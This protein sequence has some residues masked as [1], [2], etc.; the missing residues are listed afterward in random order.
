MRT[1][2]ANSPKAVAR[3]LALGMLIDGVGSFP[4]PSNM[5]CRRASDRALK[6]T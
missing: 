4:I 3:I 6:L 1:Y 5:P 2:P